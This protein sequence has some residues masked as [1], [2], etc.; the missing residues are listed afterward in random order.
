MMLLLIIFLQQH[1][2]VFYSLPES[3]NSFFQDWDLLCHRTWYQRSSQLFFTSPFANRKG[4]AARLAWTDHSFRAPKVTWGSSF[5]AGLVLFLFKTLSVLECT[6]YMQCVLG[7]T[8]LRPSGHYHSL[9]E[10]ITHTHAGPRGCAVMLFLTPDVLPVS[11]EISIEEKKKLQK[12][13]H[14]AE[15]LKEEVI[16][17]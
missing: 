3:L 13:K 7:H 4:S 2:T 10:P 15:K 17:K 16:K 12:R 9:D 6:V 1:N 11:Q 5:R 14:L 8:P